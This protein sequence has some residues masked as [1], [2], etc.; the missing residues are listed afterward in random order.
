M[1]AG[2]LGLV[3][4]AGVI[5]LVLRSEQGQKDVWL[6]V[7]AAFVAWQAWRG[8]GLGIRLQKLQPTLDA[9]NQ[10]GEALKAGQVE[11]AIAWFTQV[12]EAGGEPGVL[13]TA[14]TNRGVA[15]GRR[16]EW[17]RAIAD[18]DRAL[19]IQPQL[20]SA[21]NNLAWLLATCPVDGLRD[22]QAALKH[23]TWA[24][25]ATDWAAPHCLGTLAAAYAEVGDFGQAVQWQERALADARY[26]QT[27]G[28]DV[29]QE[30]LRMYEQG[31]PYRL[32]A[33][34]G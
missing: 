28:E 10:G 18:Y 33:K 23:A 34:G 6:L 32:P 3:A 17:Y 9:L 25:K 8:F 1:V 19:E 11:E 20:A 16:G 13:A 22:G 14:L 21:H 29:V 26:R 4:A 24:C 27:Y 12:I 5:V 7:V 15:E 30:R 2:I 31:L